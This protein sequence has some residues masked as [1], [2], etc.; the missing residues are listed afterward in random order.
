MVNDHI[1]Q[2]KLSKQNGIYKKHTRVTNFMNKCEEWQRKI[3]LL[4]HF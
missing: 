3:M 4:D 1:W 2:L